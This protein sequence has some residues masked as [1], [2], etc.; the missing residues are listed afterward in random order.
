MNPQ[1]PDT[2][3]LQEAEAWIPV[4]P[5]FP[6]GTPNRP[7]KHFFLPVPSLIY[8][9]MLQTKESSSLRQQKKKVLIFPKSAI[10]LLQFLHLR[11]LF[12]KIQFKV[13]GWGKLLLHSLFFTCSLFLFCFVFVYLFNFFVKKKKS[14]SSP[15]SFLACP[16]VA[17]SQTGTILPCICCIWDSIPWTLVRI[18]LWCAAEVMPIR[19]MSS[20]VMCTTV[21]GVVYPPAVKLSQYLSIPI[22]LSQSSTVPAEGGG[23]GL[24]GSSREGFDRRI[25]LSP[26]VL[27]R[28]LGL[29]ISLSS[30]FTICPNLGRSALSRCQQSNMSWCS[31]TGQSMGGGN[32]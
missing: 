11:H 16:S 20:C 5:G 4:H 15:R 7:W 31:A 24:P 25:V 1:I 8:P 26:P 21:S 30:M 17:M 32:R 27:F 6:K 23:S 3:L 19:V 13:H 28:V 29:R 12:F 10:F 14:L 9:W 18:L 22:A 2:S